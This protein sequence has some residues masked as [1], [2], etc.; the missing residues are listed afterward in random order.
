MVSTKSWHLHPPCPPSQVK[1][2]VLLREPADRA[3]SQ[4]LMRMRF[5]TAHVKETTHF[6]QW[7]V[8]EVGV[9]K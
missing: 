8:D 5:G 3:H 9:R 1:M 7:I 6:R 2:L 4:F